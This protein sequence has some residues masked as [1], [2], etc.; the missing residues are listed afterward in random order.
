M[1][2]I[3]EDD[4]IP[5]LKADHSLLPLFYD[6]TKKDGRKHKH[7]NELQLGLLNQLTHL[8]KNKGLI[9]AREVE[10]RDRKKSDLRFS[11]VLVN[12]QTIHAQFEIKWSDNVKADKDIKE[13]LIEKYMIAPDVGFGIY[14][15][16]WIRPNKIGHK[17]PQEMEEEI[18]LIAKEHSQ[19]I[20]KPIGVYVLDMTL[21]NA[22]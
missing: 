20:K 9:G 18:R 1:S 21:E 14:L 8:L 5:S 2:E 4:L 15:I 17:S 6:G 19:K 12:G 22:V 16:G 11:I 3:I 7:E 13:Q 10:S